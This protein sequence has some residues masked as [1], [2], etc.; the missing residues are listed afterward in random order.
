VKNS[1]NKQSLFKDLTITGKPNSREVATKEQ[2]RVRDKIEVA[3]KISGKK[4]LKSFKK[5]ER[6]LI[7]IYFDK[8]CRN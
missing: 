1:T 4:N 6:K 3:K 8:C 7:L 5:K 2:Y